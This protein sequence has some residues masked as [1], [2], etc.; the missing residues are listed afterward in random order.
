MINRYVDKARK[1]RLEMS[2]SPLNPDATLFPC[3]G[4]RQIV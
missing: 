4:D 2:L 3:D 1:K